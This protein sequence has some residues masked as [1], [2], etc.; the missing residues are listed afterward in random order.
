[1]THRTVGQGR[2]VSGPERAVT[3]PLAGDVLGQPPAVDARE[4]PSQEGS[5]GDLRAALPVPGQEV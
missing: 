3:G 2:L 1:M 4:H 5:A